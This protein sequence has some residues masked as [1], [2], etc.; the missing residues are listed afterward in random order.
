VLY[1]GLG[2]LLARAT[3]SASLPAAVLLGALAGLVWGG[4]DEGLQAFA[5]GRT[6][7]LLDLLADVAGCA[8]GAWIA[9]RARRREYN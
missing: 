8:A 6:P 5:P 4:L 9:Y 3:R 2:F 1:A 7:D